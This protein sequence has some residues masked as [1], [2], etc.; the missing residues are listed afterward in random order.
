MAKTRQNGEGS[1]YL[2]ASDG[3]WIGSVSIGWEDGKRKRKTV[4][5]KTAAEA[6]KK[7]REVQRNVDAG[8]PVA[9]SK[10]TVDHLLDRWFRD[11]L[12]H[13]VAS[14]ALANYESIAEHHIRPKLGSK[15]LRQLKP[16]DIDALLSAKLDGDPARKVRP[17]SVSTVRRIR[18]VLAQALTQAQ[19][20]ELVDRNAATLSR[21]PKAPR[22]EGRGMSPEQA[23]KFLK[24]IDGERLEAVFV[25]MLGTGLRRGEALAL[26]W[27]DIDLGHAT[28]T[29]ARQLRREDGPI[30]PETGKH[31]G[32]SLVLV[33]PKTE[34]SR[35][36]VDLPD[37]V[38]VSL[39]AHKARQ[40]AER[41]KVGAS[42]QEG[43]YVFTSGIGTPLD[44][45]NVSRQFADLAARIGLGDWHIHELRHSAASLMTAQGQ[46]IEVVS[47]VLGHSSIRMTV[48][49]YTHIAPSGRKAA[50]T[51]MDTVLAPVDELQSGERTIAP[52]AKKRA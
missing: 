32:G 10:V 18:S 38:V 41:L 49:A 51:A 47:T 12:R 20:W 27:S 39:R 29:V 42:W 45:R 14:P 19:R 15:R 6:R 11:V 23:R 5:A 46:P 43:G 2:R 26:K 17:L 21:P 48:D 7:L 28:L 16:A 52:G 13:Q 31:E 8:L 9:D 25:T 35:R 1:V 22:R 34:K 3:L 30:N 37:F 50:A 24:G 44:P 33:D 40:A 4:A 36:Q